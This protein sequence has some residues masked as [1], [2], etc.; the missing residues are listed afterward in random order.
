LICTDVA[1]RG[2]DFP[3]VDWIIHYD[4]NPNVKD[5]INRMGRTARLDKVGN[6]VM[7]LMKHELK[8]LETCLAQ[9]KIEELKQ[10]KNLLKLV[11]NLNKQIREKGEKNINEKD[12]LHI[13]PESYQDEVDENE[14]FRK[15]YWFAIYP[16]QKAIKGYILKNRNNLINARKAF[17]SSLR[18]YVTFM[19]NQKDVFNLKAMNTTRFVNYFI[20]LFIFRLGLLVFIKKVLI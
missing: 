17:K 13:H 4:I 7:F 3:M 10:G 18:S 9:F 8:I 2:L 1:A 12:L 6:S 20:Y 16:I 14:K 19:R 11:D 15:K 5:Y